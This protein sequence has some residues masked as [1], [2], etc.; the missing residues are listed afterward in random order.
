MIQYAVK[1]SYAEMQEVIE[2]AKKDLNNAELKKEVNFRIGS[3]LHWVIDYYEWAK[4]TNYVNFSDEG[5]SF[6]SGLRYANN[7]LKHDSGIIQVYERTGGFSFPIQ[8]PLRIEEVAFK[9]R[10][11]QENSAK[12]KNQ[13]RKYEEQI[14]ENDTIDIAKKALEILGLNF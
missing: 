14:S 12:W 6:F 13:H 5:I 8:F 4:E 3:F 2:K 9:W 11:I 7:K 10:K 1:R